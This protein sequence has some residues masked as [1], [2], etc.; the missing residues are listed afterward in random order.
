MD[1]SL[2]CLPSL[3]SNRSNKAWAVSL[4]EQ[5]TSSLRLKVDIHTTQT[6]YSAGSPV[7]SEYLDSRFQQPLMPYNTNLPSNTTYAPYNVP[8]QQMQTSPLPQGQQGSYRASGY[9]DGISTI[10]SLNHFI[11]PTSFGLM[12]RISAPQFPT[13]TGNPSSYYITPTMYEVGAPNF[14]PS[15]DSE[16][17]P[18]VMEGTYGFHETMDNVEDS[19]TA[20]SFA[21][22][23]ATQSWGGS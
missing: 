13:T 18:P 16:I 20:Q 9:L 8:H 10:S 2:V 21:D 1:P 17:S 12:A 7:S 6:Q 5:D 19:K 3:F 11:S 23:N 22:A 14:S 4:F 15:M